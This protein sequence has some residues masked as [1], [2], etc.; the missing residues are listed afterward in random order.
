MHY[1]WGETAAK[2]GMWPLSTM[3]IRQKSSV[4]LTVVG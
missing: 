2:K 4:T 1:H 3:R